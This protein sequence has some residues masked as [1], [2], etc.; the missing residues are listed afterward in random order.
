MDERRM[1]WNPTN[2]KVS[3]MD[4]NEPTLGEGNRDI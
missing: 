2:Y 1:L 3:S 4:V